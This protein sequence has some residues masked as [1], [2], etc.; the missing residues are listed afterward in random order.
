MTELLVVALLG[1]LVLTAVA[2][3]LI[4]GVSRY[5]DWTAFEADLQRYRDAVAAGT[6]CPRCRAANKSG[7]HFCTECGHELT[8]SQAGN[9]E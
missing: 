9:A 2:F 7:S 3:P 6:V 1:L 4:A 5:R 8:G